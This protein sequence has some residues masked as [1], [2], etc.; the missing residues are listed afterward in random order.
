MQLQEQIEQAGKKAKEMQEQF[1][2]VSRDLQARIDAERM[3]LE[4]STKAKERLL[5]D[6]N[7]KLSAQSEKVRMQFAKLSKA[8]HA[9]AKGRPG[10]VTPGEGAHVDLKKY[11]EK[12]KI[13]SLFYFIL[14]WGD[15]RTIK[16]AD[17]GCSRFL[18]FN[19]RL[20]LLS[21][22]VSRYMQI[23]LDEEGI[24]PTVTLTRYQCK[25]RLCRAQVRSWV[26]RVGKEVSA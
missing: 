4:E 5:E 3:A 10:S 17:D 18:I 25:G 15:R 24:P 20:F 23:I 19:P 16:E 9:M 13:F 1:S 21:F 6:M 7:S 14:G 11:K 8:I 22:L 2:T 26:G 12:N